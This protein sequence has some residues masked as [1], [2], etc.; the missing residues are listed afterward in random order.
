METDEGKCAYEEYIE[1]QKDIEDIIGSF[2]FLDGDYSHIN[3]AWY[4]NK[5]EEIEKDR[6]D[7]NN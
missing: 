5:M 6:A 2:K 4:E 1:L 3:V 7:L